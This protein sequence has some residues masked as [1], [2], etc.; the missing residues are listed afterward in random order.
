MPPRRLLAL[1]LFAL[2]PVA[3]QAQTDLEVRD[4][5]LRF[6]GGAVLHLTV[7]PFSART[8]QLERCGGRD[9]FPCTLGG[10]PMF[11][12]DGTEP[13]TVLTAAA[14]EVGGRRVVLD[15][16]GMANPWFDRPYD[17]QFTVEADPDLPERWRVVARLSDGAGYYVAV[18]EVA[19]GVASRTA[20]LTGETYDVCMGE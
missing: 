6:D 18:W 7:A 2:V 4:A 8:H 13:S 19:R 3:V 12:T 1:A 16:S 9:G 10:A 14:L 11:G 17:G 5:H 15:V 20:L